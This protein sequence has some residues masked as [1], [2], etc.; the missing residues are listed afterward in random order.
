MTSLLPLHVGITV[1]P[2]E[3]QERFFLVLES[4]KVPKGIRYEIQ[5][6]CQN[7]VQIVE[8]RSWRDASLQMH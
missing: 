1:E 3:Q 2:L 5:A 4:V 6:C 7:T 8:M